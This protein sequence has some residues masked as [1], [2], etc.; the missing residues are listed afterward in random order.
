MLCYAVPYLVAIGMHERAQQ[1]FVLPLIP[2][3]ALLATA[4]LVGLARFR[5]GGRRA[6]Q[7][8]AFGALALPTAA[9]AAY[10]RLHELP[11]TQASAARWL[12]AHTR[13]DELVGLHL[14]Y[15]VP[16]AR[17]IED[18]FVGGVFAGER[19]P[20][21][22]SPWQYHQ[23]NYMGP[24]WSG[25]RRA[26]AS[27]YLPGETDLAAV[28]ADPEAYLRQGGYRYVVLPGEHGASFGE[29]LVRVRAAAGNIGTLVMQ[30]PARPRMRVQ[31][32]REG[33]DT[34]HYTAFL[35]TA[36]QLGP[37]LEIYRIDPPPER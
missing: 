26:L 11:H 5:R 13:P 19:R 31:K 22:F 28:V 35:L 18:L 17:R 23:C 15:D 34:P 10:A 9:T 7:A 36:P 1:R 14:T 12:S 3:A 24:Q 2:F 6:A 21:I 32:K 25:E 37:D 8:L 16:L 27:L 30:A 29:L 20:G 4:G 33:L